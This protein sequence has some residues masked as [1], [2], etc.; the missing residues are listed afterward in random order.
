MFLIALF[1]I[2]LYGTAYIVKKYKAIVVNGLKWN[3]SDTYVYYNFQGKACAVFSNPILWKINLNTPP[4][5]GLSA[6]KIVSINKYEDF[7]QNL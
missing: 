2:T 1:H 3:L 6:I 4:A 5:T 7:L